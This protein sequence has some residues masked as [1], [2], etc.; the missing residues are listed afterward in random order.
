MATT[1]TPAAKK[2]TSTALAKKPVSST[3]LVD[4]KAQIAAQL[5]GL[6]E[7]VLPATGASVK[8]TQD[9]KFKFPDGT[10]TG[11]TFEAVVLDYVATREYYEGVYD[12]NNIEPPICFAI[13]PNPKGMIPSKNSPKLQSPECETCP[14]NQWGSD[15]KGK[16]CK[17]GRKLA[18]IP[19]DGG[20]DTPIWTLKT[21]PTAVKAFDSYV[22][23]VGRVHNTIPIGVISTIGFDP[24]LSYASVRLS[25]PEA[26]P[27]LTEQFARQAEAR[28]MLAVEPDVSSYGVEKPAPQR[29][30]AAARGARR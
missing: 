3:A 21:S 7:R 5:A 10:E 18:L 1:K 15:G 27:N 23:G 8:V 16:A 19:P 30:K 24:G 22:T 13:S 25:T 29:G 2:A 9:K 17:E 4:I 11:G 20:D 28:E 12:P 26:N 6:S 14:M